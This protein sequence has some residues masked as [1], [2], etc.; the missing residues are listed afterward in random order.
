[1]LLS[2]TTVTCDFLSLR[3]Y[4]IDLEFPVQCVKERHY[5]W[6]LKFFNEFQVNL[7]LGIYLSKHNIKYIAV[8]WPYLHSNRQFEKD[9]MGLIVILTK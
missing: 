5:M 2:V 1:M 3:L 4:F 8:G 9:C 7:M 6:I